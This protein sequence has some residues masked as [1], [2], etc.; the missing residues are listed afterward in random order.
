VGAV[1]V[2][3]PGGYE[4]KRRPGGLEL[5]FVGQAVPLALQLLITDCPCSRAIRVRVNCIAKKNKQVRFFGYHHIPN[6]LLLPLLGAGP[7]GDA[8]DRSGW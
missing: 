8:G 2:I 4:R 3:V 5:R 6:W 7:E 1:V